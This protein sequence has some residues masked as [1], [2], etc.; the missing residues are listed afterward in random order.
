MRE[1]GEEKNLVRKIFAAL[2]V[3]VL[4]VVGLAAP[5][6]ANVAEPAFDIVKV[7][8]VWDAGHTGSGAS[9]AFIDQGV[10]LTH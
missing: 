6:S 5:A 9:I 1:L 2:S 8:S 3:A 10:N 7:S 4:S